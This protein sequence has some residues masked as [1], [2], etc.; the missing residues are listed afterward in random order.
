MICNHAITQFGPDWNI[1]AAIAVTDCTD[2][3]GAQRVNPTDFDDPLTPAATPW[4][5]HVYF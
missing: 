4:G 5:W 2:I 3:H 1:L